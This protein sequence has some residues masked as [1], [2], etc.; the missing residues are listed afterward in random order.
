MGVGTFWSTEEPTTFLGSS[1]LD[2]L[3]GHQLD[4]VTP[5]ASK[6]ECTWAMRA[7]LACLWVLAWAGAVRK[8]TAFQDP[9]EASTLVADHGDRRSPFTDV[10][11]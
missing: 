8:A 11:L 3:W 6:S 1:S 2:G 7:W 5:Q 10:R 9:R 4:G